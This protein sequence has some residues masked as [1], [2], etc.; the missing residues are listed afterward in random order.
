LAPWY[1]TYYPNR[2]NSQ[3]HHL[4]N[5]ELLSDTAAPR[6]GY[7]SD[8]ED[9]LNPLFNRPIQRPTCVFI[10]GYPSVDHLPEVVI[11]ASGEAGKAWARGAQ[12]GE[13]RAVV[14]V[15]ELAV[16]RILLMTTSHIDILYK[17]WLHFLTLLVRRSDYSVRNFCKSIHLENACLC[18]GYHQFLHPQMVNSTSCRL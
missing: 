4:Q 17:G 15:D 2:C 5:V 13:Q 12:L 1:A 11:I 14:I 18:I 9:Q 10:Q 16:T 7:D 6:H 8:E 3:Q